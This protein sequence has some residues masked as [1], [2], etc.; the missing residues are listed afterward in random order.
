MTGSA[1][2]FRR[3]RVAPLRMSTEISG[4]DTGKEVVNADGDEIGVVMEVEDGTAY[5]DPVQGLDGQLKS[6]LGWGESDATTYPLRNDAIDAVTDDQ[7]RL[8]GDY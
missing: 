5:V 6:K 8:Q 1:G 7:I 4:D 3:L 2:R